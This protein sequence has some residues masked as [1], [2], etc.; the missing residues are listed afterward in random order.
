MKWYRSCAAAA[1]GLFVVG[2]ASTSEATGRRLSSEWSD[3]NFG[4]AAECSG[5]PL[6]F[7]TKTFVV[8]SFSLKQHVVYVELSGQGDVHGNE[9]LVL[10]CAVDGVACN[11]SGNGRTLMKLPSD[12]HDNTIAA[13]WCLPVTPRTHTLELG[14]TAE[15]GSDCVFIENMLISISAADEG[16]C[17]AGTFSAGP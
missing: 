2:L 4:E 9:G 14:I 6:V 11:P 17:V 16:N 13:H 3:G 8:P 7:D 12:E 15:G 5:T 10:S 1:A